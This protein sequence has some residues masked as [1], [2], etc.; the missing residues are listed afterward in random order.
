[1]TTTDSTTHRRPSFHGRRFWWSVLAG[2]ILI[3]A[4]FIAAWWEAPAPS[5]DDYLSPNSSREIGSSILAEEL[6][7]E[8]IEVRRYTDANEGLR[9]AGNGSTVFLPAPDYL[10]PEDLHLLDSLQYSDTTIVMVQPPQSMMVPLGVRT[11]G[12]ARIAT[13][14]VQSDCEGIAPAGAV[15][16]GRQAYQP[17]TASPYADSL[18]LCYDGYLAVQRVG[19]AVNI[20]VGSGDPFGNRRIDEVDNRRF[21]VELLNDHDRLIWIDVHALAKP[22]EPTA[23]SPS[24]WED[25]GYSPEPVEIPYPDS[26]GT[27]PLYDALPSW[28]WA[29][30]VG[31]LIM[32]VLAALWR[33]RRLGPPVVEP[34]PVS[35]RAAET[36]HGRAMLY[37]RAGAYPQ[38]L[39]ALRA[40]ALHRIRAVVGLSSR[41]PE[42]DVVAAVSVRTGWPE[43]RV[44]AVLFTAQAADERDLLELSAMLDRLLAAIEDAEPQ[45]RAE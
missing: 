7:A 34:L 22:P 39:R 15:Q 14:T 9:A 6:S 16:V 24:R 20:A 13:K 38:A 4:T 27:N 30:L 5:A 26:F 18:R 40:G 8:G 37:R 42:D 12:G 11:D 41:T 2:V 44:A 17:D 19:A 23:P 35:V 28:M 10:T 3:V 43:G 1:M 31:L 36:V 29:G 32:M 45:G 21:A 25:S 33:G